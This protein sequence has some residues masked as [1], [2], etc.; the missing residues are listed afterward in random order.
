MRP[1]ET[2]E[3][4]ITWGQPQQRAAML[5]AV[6]QL[7]DRQI[8]AE[9]GISKATLERWKQ[10]SEFQARVAE[11]RS[12]ILKAVRM[13]GIAVVEERLAAQNA[14]WMALR[15]IVRERRED[16]RAQDV[17]GGE[18]GYLIPV[19]KL[20]KVYTNEEPKRPEKRPQGDG[21]DLD[22]ADEFEIEAEDEPEYLYSARCHEIVI[23]WQ[24]DKSILAE[25]RSLEELAGK[26]LGQHVHRTELTGAHGGPVAIS[27]GPDLSK[28]SLADL[29]QLNAIYER[30]LEPGSDPGGDVPA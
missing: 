29:E 3:S 26:E 8:A 9:V 30:A 20:V 1:N 25:I 17:P 15:R 28:L 2:A 21:E 6:D 22:S 12:E 24:L 23:E 13:E 14:R 5:V 4:P 18:T 11:H 19:A 16:P 7:S 10:H 27:T